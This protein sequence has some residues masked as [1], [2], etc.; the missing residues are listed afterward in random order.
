M[1]F[2]IKS[3]D[4]RKMVKR[5]KKMHRRQ[6]Q[7]KWHVHFAL[8]PVRLDATT[9]AWMERVARRRTMRDGKTFEVWRFSYYHSQPFEFGPIHNVLM[10]PGA[11]AGDAEQLN[12]GQLAAHNHGYGVS[13]AQADSAAIQGRL[14]ATLGNQLQNIRALGQANDGNPASRGFNSAAQKPGA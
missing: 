13:A 14:A 5:F 4:E 11:I 12:V 7:H 1:K 3:M 9:V 6:D 10:Q 8:W 2:A